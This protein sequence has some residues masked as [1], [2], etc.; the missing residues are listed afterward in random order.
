MVT[1][2]KMKETEMGYRVSKSF[3]SIYKLIDKGVKEQRVD[4]NWCFLNSAFV[5][6]LNRER[7]RPTRKHLRYTLMG[8]ERGYQLEVLSTQFKKRFFSL[9]KGNITLNPYFITGFTDAPLSEKEV[10]L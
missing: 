4:G 3:E 5:L 7:M 2:H 9:E 1:V 8:L 6:L 10:L